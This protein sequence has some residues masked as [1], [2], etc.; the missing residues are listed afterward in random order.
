MSSWE[1]VNELWFPV[2]FVGEVFIFYV[3]ITI[4]EHLR[5]HLIERNILKN[6]LALRLEK[7]LDDIFAI[8]E[9]KDINE[10]S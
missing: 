10:K 4:I 7:K 2:C 3:F 9:F 6:K 8:E 1:V 5:T